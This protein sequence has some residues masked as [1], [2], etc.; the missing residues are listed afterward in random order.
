MWALMAKAAQDKASGDDPFYS[1][2][3]KTARYF[4]ERVFPDAASHLAKLRTGADSMMALDAEA[5]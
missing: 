1:N 3:L 4:V 5:F 2:K